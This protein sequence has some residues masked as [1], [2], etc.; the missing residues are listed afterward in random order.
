M[1]QFKKIFLE[2]RSQSEDEEKLDTIRQLLIDGEDFDFVEAEYGDYITGKRIITE[3]TRKEMKR[4]LDDIQS[5]KFARDWMQE[6][7]VNQPS[8][9]ATRRRAAER[10]IEEVGIKFNIM[11]ELVFLKNNERNIYIKNNN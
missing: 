7:K 8:F 2:Y 9:K 4:V 10:K 1:P 5:G 3:D 11:I 6:C